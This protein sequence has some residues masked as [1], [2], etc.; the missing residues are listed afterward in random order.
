MPT[1]PNI[2]WLRQDLRLRDHPALH[3]AAKCDAPLLPVYIWE[4]DENDRWLPGAA[5]RTW[6]HHALEILEKELKGLGSCLVLKKG[7]PRKVLP[8]LAKELHV[9]TVFW[10]RRYEPAAAARDREIHKLLGDQGQSVETFNG[11]LLREPWEVTNEHDQP[12]RVFTPYWKRCIKDWEP[13]KT[14]PAPTRLPAPPKVEGERLENLHLL[15]EKEG[16]WDLKLD[17]HWDIGEKGGWKHLRAFVEY[18][19]LGGYSN[20][21]NGLADQ[22]TSSLSPY[23]HWGHLSPREIWWGVRERLNANKNESDGAAATSMHPFTRQL[24]WREF[25]YSML[26]HFPHTPDEPLREEFAHFPWK[27]H[28]ENFRRW[29]KGKTGFPIVDAGMNQLWQEGWLHNRARMVV[30]SFL[31]KDLMIHWQAGARWFWDTLVDADLANNSMGWQWVAGCGADSAPYFRIFNPHSQAQRF[32]A[33]GDYVR[34][35]VPQLAKLSHQ[36][37]HSPWELAEEERRAAG[38]QSE[39]SY[40]KPMVDHSETRK[41]A[42]ASYG[43]MRGK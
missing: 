26:M 2:L 8:K 38:I 3:A 20:R 23:L 29:S 31:V 25:S 40:P 5:A 22:G 21:R 34:R 13:D 10:T 43:A 17:R 14:L 27:D 9:G 35:Y 24:F 42:L 36:T 16:R 32:D 37:V 30:A 4:T 28:R 6:L 11:R 19:G 39:E 1:S 41:Q 15:P 33:D 7:D 18:E 12:L